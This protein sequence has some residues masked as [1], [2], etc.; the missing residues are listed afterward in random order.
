VSFLDGI[1]RLVRVTA[2]IVG[3]APSANYWFLLQDGAGD[4]LEH[5]ASVTLGV[6][7]AAL[8]ADPHASLLEIAHEFF[9][10]WNL[11]AISPDRYQALSFR[12][13]A[14]TSGLWMG[15]GV[16]VYY[17]NALL[18][19]A[20]LPTAEPTRVE[21]VRQ[22]LETYYGAAWA[23]HVSPEAASLALGHSA[24]TDP[25]ATGGYYLQGELL[26]YA[27]DA[28]IRDSTADARGLDDVMRA[29]YARRAAGGFTSHGLESIVDSVCHCRLDDLF[30][31][32][33][34][35]A[36]LI[37]LS[38]AFR[39]LG[40]R[41]EVDTIDAT[42]SAGHAIPDRRLGIDFARL[43]P[44]R[45]VIADTARVWARAGLR[46]GDEMRAWNGHPLTTWAQLRDALAA[47]RLGDTVTVDV[48]RDARPVR[49]VVHV[50]GYRRPHV[51]LVER[52]GATRTERGRLARW[53]AGW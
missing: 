25:N 20:H 51:Q 12:P 19:R 33:V 46:S 3:G 34:R 52:S 9:H 16:T 47:L 53:E 14:A 50:M 17:A 7:S 2:D 43:D 23:T 10:T 28:A 42:D 45:L 27:L 48:M 15:E 38:P 1:K 22:L 30:A 18:R 36:S 6:A 11:V 13:A 24:L 31:H 4:A 29:L 26:A 37:D 49:A 44:L 39:R 5:R 40:M 32:E 21:H 8:A 35:G 41:L